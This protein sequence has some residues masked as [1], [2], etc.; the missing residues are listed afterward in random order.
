MIV[1][2]RQFLEDLG[3][4][5]VL[6]D[7]GGKVELAKSAEADVS[8]NRIRHWPMHAMLVDATRKWRSSTRTETLTRANASWR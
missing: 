3:R 8:E 4:S 2:A 6:G 7:K 5:K 1:L